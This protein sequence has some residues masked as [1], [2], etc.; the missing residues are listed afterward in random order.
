M[1]TTERP[2]IGRK[3]SAGRATVG[4]VVAALTA[5]DLP[6]RVTAY[7]GTALGPPD[8]NLRLHIADERGLSYLLTAPG[9]L[10][11]ARAY[12]SGSLEL[13]GVHPGDLFEAL[14]LVH[15]KVRLRRPS[16]GE[17]L[18]LARGLG[19][20]RLLPPPPPPQEAPPR[21]RRTVIGLRHSRARDASAVKH[22]YDVSNAFYSYVLGPSMTYSCAVFRDPRKTL[23]EA[24]AAKYEL[25]AQKLA[26]RPGLRLL[27]VGCGWGGMV[28]HVAREHGARVLGVTLSRQQA[29]WGQAAIEHEGLSGLAEVRYLDYRDAGRGGGG[30]FDAISSIGMSEHVGLRNYPNY[31]ATLRSLLRPGGRLL[32]HC[33]TRSDNR[34]SPRPGAFIDRYVFPDGELPSP[35]RVVTEAHDVG[36][37]VQHTENL[38]Q[39]YPLTLAAWGRNLVEHWGE[40]VREAGVATA[41]VWG[42]YMAAA[43]LSFE[44]NDLQ[45]H[46][47]LATRTEPGTSF[48]LHPD[49]SP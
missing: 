37:E 47:V 23:E 5:G 19:W 21:W 3:G 30:G 32:N 9:D 49:W 41:R 45:L 26:L 20:K 36:L 27:D 2:E 31:F 39:H 7:D 43:R 18:S 4:D 25:V 12:T 16:A 29:E 48:P 10:G 8:S 6:V 35:G 17:V 46:Q 44:Q 40:C 38:R 13:H 15:D 14:R 22:H 1:R 42:L 33:I 34:A 28:R 11:L 24:Q